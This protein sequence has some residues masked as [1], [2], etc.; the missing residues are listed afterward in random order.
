MR[1]ELKIVEHDMGNG[2][3]YPKQYLQYF[4]TKTIGAESLQLPTFEW[5]FMIPYWR[6][7]PRCNFSETPIRE[8]IGSGDC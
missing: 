8:S 3:Y 4:F 6:A 2:I 1:K 5:L 7:H